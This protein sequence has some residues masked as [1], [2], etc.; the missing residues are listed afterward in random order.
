M[1]GFYRY[2]TYPPPS[3]LN[4]AIIIIIIVLL[5]TLHNVCFCPWLSISIDHSLYTMHSNNPHKVTTPYHLRAHICYRTVLCLFRNYWS[6][7]DKSSLGSP[8]KIYFD[9][10]AHYNSRDEYRIT[11]ICSICI[12]NAVEN[13]LESNAYICALLSLR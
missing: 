5:Q 6:L 11:S 7:C 9:F 2:C 12:F 4:K 8:G 10:L 13:H 3:R 1:N